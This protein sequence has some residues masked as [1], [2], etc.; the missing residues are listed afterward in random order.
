MFATDSLSLCDSRIVLRMDAHLVK[1]NMRFTLTRA[2]MSRSDSLLYC[3]TDAK[4][5]LNYIQF[6]AKHRRNQTILKQIRKHFYALN[7]RIIIKN[8]VLSP[9]IF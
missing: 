4:L 5:K 2:Q 1:L 9:T 6:I 8:V 7:V 3:V